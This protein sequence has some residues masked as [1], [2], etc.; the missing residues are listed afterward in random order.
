MDHLIQVGLVGL[1]R[2]PQRTTTHDRLS[3]VN[4]SEEKNNCVFRSEVSSLANSPPPPLEPATSAPRSLSV[5]IIDETLQV[6]W[7]RTEPKPEL[8]VCEC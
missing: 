6:S 3:Q 4:L 7:Y 1:P 5:Y 8:R 2:I